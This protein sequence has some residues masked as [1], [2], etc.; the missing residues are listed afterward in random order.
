V[1]HRRSCAFTIDFIVL[2][3]QDQIGLLSIIFPLLILAKFL[4]FWPFFCYIAWL[5]YWPIPMKNLIK[6]LVSTAVLSVTLFSSS[7]AHAATSRSVSAQVLRNIENAESVDFR[8]DVDVETSTEHLHQPVKIHV[9]LDVVS[10]KAQRSRLDFG[11]VTTDEYGAVNEAR[12]SMI[13]AEDTLFISQDGKDWYSAVQSNM[14]YPSADD[15]EARVAEMQSLFQEMVDGG[16]VRYSYTGLERIDGRPATRY[17]YTVSTDRFVD[18]LVAKDLVSATEADAARTYLAEHVTIGGSFW[19]DVKT[20]LPAQLTLN[21]NVQQSATSYTT[22]DASIL[23]VSFNAPVN[24]TLPTN[25]I[26]IENFHMSQNSEATIEHLSDV[27]SVMDSDGDGVTNVDET[28]VWH[29]NPMSADTDSDGYPDYIEIINGYDPN[30]VGKLDSD[31]DGLTDY[32][33]MTIHWTN[34]YD[35]DSDNDGYNDGL[36]IA[37]GYNPNGPGRW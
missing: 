24:I 29:S 36:E 18:Y 7:V 8:V 28:Q 21:V 30:G 19:I 26:D 12:G 11:A 16:V 2:G 31:G 25:T 32:A 17:A 5:I 37:N 10:A 15:T 9:D 27:V 4:D 3:F 23:F 35:A 1:C 34:R 13:L 6:K 33:E 20:M 22:I 14:Y